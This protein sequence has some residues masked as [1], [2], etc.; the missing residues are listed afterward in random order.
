MKVS[1]MQH[2]VTRTAGLADGRMHPVNRDSSSSRRRGLRSLGFADASCIG[3]MFGTIV[4]AEVV[5]S[6]PVQQA[7]AYRHAS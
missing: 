7:F 4:S 2:N 5:C 6:G 1:A 3:L